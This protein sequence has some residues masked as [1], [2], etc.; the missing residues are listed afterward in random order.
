MKSYPFSTPVH[1]YKNI[2]GLNLMSEAD[3]VWHYPDGEFTY[4]RFRLKD[5]KY[6]AIEQ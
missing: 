3:A 5:I 2:N 1:A 4:G 6:N